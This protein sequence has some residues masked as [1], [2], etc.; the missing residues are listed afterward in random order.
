MVE[1]VAARAALAAL[2][3]RDVFVRMPAVAPIDRCVRVTV[4]V[5]A[6]R[7]AF[8]VALREVLRGIPRSG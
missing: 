1:A 5:A 8:A 4:G 3:E 7:E 6:D 2:L